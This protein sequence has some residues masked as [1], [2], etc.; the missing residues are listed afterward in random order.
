MHNS[1]ATVEY[2][3]PSLFR[4]RPRMGI[5]MHA[6]GILS[7]ASFEQGIKDAQLTQCVVTRLLFF[8]CFLPPSLQARLCGAVPTYVPSC[9]VVGVIVAVVHEVS[10]YM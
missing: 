3:P 2:S 10:V 7:G 4:P 1:C 5:S 8:F 6:C 9:I